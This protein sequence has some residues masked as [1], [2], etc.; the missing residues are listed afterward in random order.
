M[1]YSRKKSVQSQ[2]ISSKE[3]PLKFK[4]VQSDGTGTDWLVGTAMGVCYQDLFKK[5][6]CREL[7]VEAEVP[8]YLQSTEVMFQPLTAHGRI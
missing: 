8:W 5:C 2:E 3:A 6:F 4:I 7:K 1:I